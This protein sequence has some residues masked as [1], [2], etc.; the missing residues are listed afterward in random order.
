MAAV[1]PGQWTPPAGLADPDVAGPTPLTLDRVVFRSDECPPEIGFGGAQITSELIAI[2]GGRT[3]QTLGPN[4][5]D[6]KWSGAFWGPNVRPRVTL[7]H[8]YWSDGKER[9][10][11]YFAE[12]YYVVV[13]D[14]KPTYQKP[15]WCKYDITVKVL[16]DA[17]GN[18]AKASTPSST[19][20]QAQNLVNS[21]ASG[22]ASLSAL[23]ALSGVD[24]VGVSNSVA[25]V[26]TAIAA[27]SPLSQ[28]TGAPLAAVNAALA[29]AL[30][31]VQT[32]QSGLTSTA[33]LGYVTALSQ[34]RSAI[35][36]LQKN[37]ATG[38]A[39]RTV[40]VQGGNLDRIA[41]QFYG[42]ASLGS[43]IGKANG[44]SSRFLPSTTMLDLV[45]PPFTSSTS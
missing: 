32:A 27:S 25:A 12:A 19:D 23:P 39:P 18:Y 21:A 11:T 41:A 6:V 17:S 16:R 37:A 1:P 28:A 13:T 40:R 8:Q 14:F 22:A 33:G 3:I 45:L 31:V 30:S 9:L 35:V 4:P 29:A 34:I 24:A 7:L 5:H 20:S 2:G 10:L 38:Q 44:L 15:F 36:L 26:S 43:A 42:D